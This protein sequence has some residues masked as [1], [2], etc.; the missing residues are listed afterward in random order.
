MNSRKNLIQSNEECF[1]KRLNFVNLG[2]L[3]NPNFQC[4]LEV[5]R[6]IEINNVPGKVRREFRNLVVCKIDA[7][8]VSVEFRDCNQFQVCTVCKENSCLIIT[9]AFCV[10]WTT[11]PYCLDEIDKNDWKNPKNGLLNY[12]HHH[13]KWK[14]NIK[15]CKAALF[16]LI[17]FCN[18]CFYSCLF[19]VHH[20]IMYAFYVSVLFLFFL[21]FPP[22]IHIVLITWGLF[23]CY[24]V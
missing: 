21:F 6:E 13:W 9:G 2:S 15:Y 3:L 16:L 23:V 7:T 8:N 20:F 4:S 5:L 19:I 1:W 11:K 24:C 14:E 12:M 18:F 17:W 22:M 10:G